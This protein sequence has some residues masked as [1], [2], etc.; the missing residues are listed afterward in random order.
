SRP[1]LPAGA[2]GA[3]PRVRLTAVF[4]QAGVLYLAAAA[5]TGVGAGAVTDLMGGTPAEEPARYR[6][7]DPLARLPLGVPLLAVHSRADTVVPFAQS[8]HFVTAAVAAGDD[9]A[10]LEVHGDHMSLIDPGSKA[11]SVVL[12]ALPKLLA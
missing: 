11:W 10:L 12:D 9:A 3:A 4:S 1:G 2:P 6:L 8:A 7:A 5:D